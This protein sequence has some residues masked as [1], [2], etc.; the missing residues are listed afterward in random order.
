MFPFSSFLRNEFKVVVLE[1][2]ASYV[3][4]MS[5]PKI[6]SFLVCTIKRASSALLNRRRDTAQPVTLVVLTPKA[7]NGPFPRPKVHHG[8]CYLEIYGSSTQSAASIRTAEMIVAA[9][10]VVID[11]LGVPYEGVL[12]RGGSAVEKTG[13][14]TCAIHSGQLP[15]HKRVS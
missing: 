8:R 10:Q 6:S 2:M 11:F 7:M 15:D 13:V 14:S 9:A 12:F 5:F 3:L 4:T 1:V